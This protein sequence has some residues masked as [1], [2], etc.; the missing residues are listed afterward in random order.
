LTIQITLRS[1]LAERLRHLAMALFLLGAA[2]LAGVADAGNAAI[3]VDATTGQVLNEVNADQ[4]NYPASLAKMMTLYL[5]FQ[6]LKTGQLT[7]DQPLTVSNWAAA[8]APTKLGLRPGETISVGDCILAMVTKSAN[9]AAT[10]VAEG[11]GGSESRFAD[12][13]NAQAALL[14]M[15]D[16]HF[17]NAS[18]LPDP[19]NRTTARDMAKLAMALY[20]DFPEYDHYFATRDFVFRGRLVRGHNHLMDRY[21]GMDGLKTGYTVASGFNLASTAVRDD[22]RL[23]AVVLGGRT[24][25]G[26]DRQMAQ[27]LDDGFDQAGDPASAVD[28]SGSATSQGGVGTARRMLSA[29]SPISDA[30]AGQVVQA[31]RPVHHRKVVK[32]AQNSCHSRKHAV[33]PSHGHHPR[34]ATTTLAHRDAA[35]PVNDESGR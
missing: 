5:T 20:R 21:P 28:V 35:K 9:D 29:L 26:R 2:T 12:M 27:L 1:P 23:F 10:V 14:G 30:E 11:I 24:A 25:A 16:S 4:T 8:K 3:V 32:V 7:V 13:M 22:R 31:P 19:E 18:G 34:H 17:D 6:G 33:C 15:S